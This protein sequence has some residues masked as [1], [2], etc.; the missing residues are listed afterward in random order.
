MAAPAA[1]VQGSQRLAR[2]LYAILERDR[3]ISAADL[4]V[5]AYRAANYPGQRFLAV[6][7]VDPARVFR[8]I[9]R[10]V[11]G[12][13]QVSFEPAADAFTGERLQKCAFIR[14]LQPRPADYDLLLLDHQARDL[15]AGS[16]AQF[17]AQAFLDS[18]PAF[19]PRAYTER[20]YRGLASAHNNIRARL[21]EEQNDD[22]A[23]RIQAAVTG[24]R[25][26][27]DDWV[28]QLPLPD[29]LK[30]EIDSQVR[31]QVPDREFELDPAYS[32]RLT[33]KVRFRGEGDLL[34][35]VRSSD[36]ARVIKS[37]TQV[38]EPGR[39][40]F[41]RVILETEEWKKV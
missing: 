37:V 25:I 6:L 4:A 1:F 11:G 12:Q 3:R 34:V 36:A 32:A 35:R 40:P 28:D 5:C 8:H 17:F 22:L 20:L 13:V 39:R 16:I 9:V 19:D 27:L 24:E 21:N 18:E 15:Q 26:D 14:P 41:Y 38:S 2:A 29:E 31:R 7:K 33:Q 30:G 10:Q 23:E